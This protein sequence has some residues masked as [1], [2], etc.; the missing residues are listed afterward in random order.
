MITSVDVLADDLLPVINAFQAAHD[1]VR[2]RYVSS[3]TTLSLEY[4]E[5]HIAFR[6]GKKPQD[7]G[8]IVRPFREIEIGLYAT[9]SYVE[10]FG[11]PEG[12]DDYS[13]HRF[14][15]PATTAPRAVFLVWMLKHV[16]HENITFASNQMSVL[17]SAVLGGAGIGFVPA[18]KA[19]ALADV[20]EVLPPRSLWAVPV[21]SVTHVD[22]HRSAKVRAFLDVLKDYRD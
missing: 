4:G 11:L 10:H 17:T 18:A 8:N 16:P 1:R 13:Q 7:P 5:A 9:T 6:V 14:V 3:E 21:W 12:P 19:R 2:V 22:L 15:G 20:V